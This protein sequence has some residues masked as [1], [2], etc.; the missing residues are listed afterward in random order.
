[1]LQI[2]ITCVARHYSNGH[3]LNERAKQG[4]MIKHV[5]NIS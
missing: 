4:A 5:A 2:K 1:M 3:L